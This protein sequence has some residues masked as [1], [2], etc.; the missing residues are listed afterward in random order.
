MPLNINVKT[1]IIINGKEYNSQ[2]ELPPEL[3]KVYDQALANRSASQQM[4]IT[5]GSK[6]TFNGQ[7]YNNREEM[8]EEVRRIYDSAVDAIDKNHDGIPDALQKG[9]LEVLPTPGTS[10]PMAPLP[11]QQSPISP[12]RSDQWRTIITVMVSLF[13]LLVA[14][15]VLLWLRRGG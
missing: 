7:T 5:S 14:A 9:G 2:D 1:K 11:A 13:L 4:Q 12:D 6:I 10:T 3:R 8:P 15:L